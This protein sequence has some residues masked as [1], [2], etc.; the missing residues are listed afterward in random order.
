VGFILCSAGLQPAAPAQPGNLNTF[1][2]DQIDTRLHDW[3]LTV[4]DDV[5]ISLRP[6]DAETTGQGVSLYLLELVDDPPLRGQ[7][8]PPLQLALRYLVTTWAAEPAAAH[9]LLG[10]LAFSAMT[11]PDLAVELQPPTAATW[12]ALNARPQPAF[13]LRVPLRQHRPQPTIP[14]VR[15][16][17]VIQVEPGLPTSVP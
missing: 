3:I 12:Q 15:A 17:L 2:I 16:P 9:R 14:L 13:I 5:T 7:Q 11:Q 10:Q 1:M 8:P 4:L 6:P